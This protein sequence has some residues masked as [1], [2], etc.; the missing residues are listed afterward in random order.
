[1]ASLE[2]RSGRYRIIFRYGGIKYHH[3][4]GKIPAARG[5][6]MS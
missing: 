4:L 5:I 3:K 1:M 2:N 6:L